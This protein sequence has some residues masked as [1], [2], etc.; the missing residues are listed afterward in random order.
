MTKFIKTALPTLIILLL[1][2]SA[3]AAQASS[4]KVAIKPLTPFV[5]KTGDGYDGFSIDLWN[6]I[7]RRNG[8]HTE[9]VWRD[10][11]KDLLEVV[12]RGEADAG[13]SGISMTKE[14]EEVLDF[15]YPIF[16][17]GLQ[18]MT[19]DQ[20]GFS[21]MGFLGSVFNAGLLRVI[22]I[23]VLIM[24]VAGHVIWLIE[25]RRDP[26]FPKTYLRGVWEGMWWAGVNLATGGFGERS[27]RSVVGRLAALAWIFTGI[28]LIAN[29]TAATTTNLTLQEIRGNINGI[30]DLPGKR[31]VTVADTTASRYLDEQH[32]PFT[33]VKNIDEA[34]SLLDRQQADAVVYDAPVLLYYA[35]TAGKGKVRMVGGIFKQEFYGIA[36]PD[37]SL[38][39]EAVD[40]TLLDIITDGTYR[41]I[42]AR[43][44]GSDAR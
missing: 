8:W 6:E 18:V 22:G 40:R 7:A 19:P 44:F 3:S 17:A 25:R 13:I 27:P 30:K 2:P 26:N 21:L 10:T 15:S 32:V 33:G 20:T 28:I 23:M 34:Y 24:L 9:F 5:M 42:Y 14:R 4:L 37:R 1:V 43:W 29:F 16:S 41:E 39:R 11:V 31:V 35:N 38:L 12:K 36:L